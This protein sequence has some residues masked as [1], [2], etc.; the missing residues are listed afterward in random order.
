MKKA[1]TKKSAAEKLAKLK[2]TSESDIIPY[3]K[4]AKRHP[5]KQLKEIAASVQEFGWRQPIV[6]DRNNVIIVGHGRYF[7]YQKYGA[8][9]NLKA[10]WIERAIDLNDEQVKAYR[11]ADNK[12]NES[13]W[14][15]QLVIDELRGLSPTMLDLTGF[16]KDLVLET[17]AKDDV[18][19]EIPKVAKARKGDIYQV[20]N[21]R[22]MCG[23]A[24]DLEDV[25]T[26]MGG[27]A[28]D[29][30]FT[31][32]PYNVNY[33]GQGKETK[34]HIQNDNM[35][36]DA[37]TEFLLKTFQNYKEA[38]KKGAGMYVFHS[39]STQR[40]FENA[41]EQAGF[42]IKNQLIWNKPSSALGWGNYRWKHE[43]FFYV[44]IKGEKIQFYG[45]RSHATVWDFQKTEKELVLWAK[46]MKQYEE[47]GK[48]TIWSMKRS[49][50]QDY[51]HPT[52]KPVELV[53]YAIMNSSKS[54]DIV[55]DLF[56]GSGSTLIACEKTGRISYGME[57]DPKYV[58]TIIKRYED[59]T[60]E[61][62]KQI[63]SAKK[64]KK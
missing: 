40:Q 37:F 17:D 33:K 29:M 4:N 46:R 10:P 7:A 59:Y 27:G 14:D 45:D 61:K 49:N 23:D 56:M 18:V 58:D 38:N 32:P 6:V 21:H 35:S 15:M 47:Q 30:V 50:V 57:L 2:E 55:L 41:L 26:L 54:G 8:E 24:T 44:G 5:D 52:Q 31:D 34:N 28:A 42:D 3:E 64:A 13:E 43:P 11:L 36:T 20:G 62:A 63:A 9:M 16:D 22:L 19:P 25:K 39:S 60:G 53:S 48:T 12:L 51:V 1:V